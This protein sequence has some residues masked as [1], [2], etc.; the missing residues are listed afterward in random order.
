M[1]AGTLDLPRRGGVAHVQEDGGPVPAVAQALHEVEATAVARPQPDERD[2]RPVEAHDFDRLGVGGHSGAH[3]D[4]PVLQ[5]SGK[6]IPHRGLVVDDHDI[7]RPP[8]V[9]PHG[10]KSRGPHLAH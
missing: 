1:V 3:D 9:T 6:P 7:D 8:R 4:L 2:R 10:R 5:E